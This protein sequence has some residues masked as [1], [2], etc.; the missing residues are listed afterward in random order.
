L[1]TLVANPDARAEPAEA[2]LSL[3]RRDVA[4]G[5]AAVGVAAAVG[6][7]LLVATS[8]HLLRPLAYGLQLTVIV[9]GT[10][11]VA[12]YWAVRRPG[13]RI[14]LVLLAYAAAA[15]GLAL[16]GASEPLLHSIGVLFDAPMFLLGY[17]LVFIFPSGRLAGALEKVLTAAI[18]CALLL[19]FL[20]WFFFSPVVSGGAPLAR[21][22]A[23]CPTNVLM[24]ANEPSIAKGFGK[25]EEY[26]SVFVAAA[27]V[28]G[29]C[30]LLVRAS[31]PRR[32]ALLPVY[33]PALFVT[34][35][36]AIFHSYG[37]G[38]ISPSLDTLDTIGWFLTAGRTALTFGFLVAIWQ[39]MLF[40]GVA[41]TTI[42]RRVGD[43]ADAARLR[44]LVAEALDD[45][46]LE[47][48]FEVDRRGAL[49]V[50]S[51]GDPI[52]VRDLGPKTT[53][54]PLQ[55][56][57]ETVAYLVHD[58]ALET[59]PELVEAAGQAV[60]LALEGGRLESELQSKIAE[61]RRSNQRI[62]SAGA[63]ERRRIER[64][65]HDGAQ[66]RL[67]GIQ[68]KLGLL[69]ARVDEPELASELDEIEEDANAAV[70]ELRSLA[71]GIYPAVLR[72]RGLGDGVRSLAR[73]AP[74]RVDVVD[75]G[76]GRCAP[77]VEAMLYFCLVEAIQNATKH[78]GPGARVTVTLERMGGEV[79]F[80][81]ADEGAGF[82]P[83]RASEGVG[84]RSMRD[85]IG[86]VGGELEIR[87]SPG[88]GTRV[89]ATVPDD[90]AVRVRP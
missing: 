71:H 90:T 25:A 82:D 76:I 78:A 28:V 53:A 46:S 23:A 74:V 69:R 20:P 65:L 29:L 61:L 1:S 50:D 14:A 17:Y 51:R 10:V 4:I 62:V 38:F 58:A 12:L 21:C 83:T 68:I 66:Q 73:T 63:A 15:A 32:R 67:M 13:N 31:G 9:A 33:V 55:W 19:S 36:F 24:I 40:A 86:A 47:V 81:V 75:T 79:Q 44:G 37:A 89:R 70:D 6:G 41:L 59:D 7:G 16:Q 85:R 42:M 43:E 77:V 27:I 2:T 54:T 56:H 60:L 8:D 22:N 84:L 35:P 30:Y 88:A 18:A 64:D 5:V 26:F 52:D 87:S 45:P 34:V 80:V 39:A 72:E 3:A 49:L 11:G 48:A 57:G